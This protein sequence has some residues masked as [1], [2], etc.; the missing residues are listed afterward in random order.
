MFWDRSRLFKLIGFFCLML[1]QPLHATILSSTLLNEAQQLA[2]IDPSQARQAATN[3]LL[4]RE[5]IERSESDG[6]S[7]MSR[8]ETDRSIRNPKQHHRST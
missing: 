4:Q 8:E 1:A 3:Y 5:L 7:A 6:P 2:E